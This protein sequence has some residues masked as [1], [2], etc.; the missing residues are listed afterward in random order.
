MARDTTA[1]T[2]VQWLPTG[3]VVAWKLELSVLYKYGRK[4]VGDRAAKSSLSM[5]RVIDSKYDIA[6][7]VASHDGFESVERSF[8]ETAGK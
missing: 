4:L 1:S 6:L 3:V 8:V 2:S 7:Y 5:A